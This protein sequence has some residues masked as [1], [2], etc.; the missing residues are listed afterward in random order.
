M[1]SCLALLAAFGIDPQS[2]DLTKT[3]EIDRSFVERL[4]R[5]QQAEARYCAW[6]YKIK[7]RVKQ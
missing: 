1:T 2:I 7:W 5:I 4:S 3:Y 6:R